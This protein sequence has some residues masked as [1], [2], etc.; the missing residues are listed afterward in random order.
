M[1][2]IVSLL[3][4]LALLAAATVLG[5]AW[6][7][8]T[9]RVHETG[10]TAGRVVTIQ[11]TDVA[12]PEGGQPPLFGAGATLLQF[13]TEFCAP[14]RTTHTLLA[15]IAD[16]RDDVVHLDIDL[17]NRPE[18]ARRYSVMQTPTTLLLDAGGVVRARI[19]G[20]PRGTELRAA[21]ETVLRRSATAVPTLEKSNA[22]TVV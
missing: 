10:S 6:R 4:V 20:A 21:L 2:P 5:L 1:N 3:I 16:E 15:G 8:R 22:H 11:P 13:S 12:A 19:G 14:C 18:L 7:T 17:T 9:G